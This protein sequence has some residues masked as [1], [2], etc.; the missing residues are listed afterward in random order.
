MRVVHLACVTSASLFRE[1]SSRKSLPSLFSLS[2]LSLPLLPLR[3]LSERS[4]LRAEALPSSLSLSLSPLIEKDRGAAGV[5]QFF[6][7]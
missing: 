6:L 3:P 7:S 5:A 2:S 1:D 4:P